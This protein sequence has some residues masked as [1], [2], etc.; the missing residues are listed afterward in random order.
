MDK[1]NKYQ[2]NSRKSSRWIERNEN[3]VMNLVEEM[4]DD[5]TEIKNIPKV[6]IKT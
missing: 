5:E 3:N 1:L 2:T 6:I 4:M